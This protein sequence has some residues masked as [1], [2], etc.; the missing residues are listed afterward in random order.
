EVDSTVVSTGKTA[1]LVVEGTPGKLSPEA[2]DAARKANARLKVHPRDL[3]PNTAALAR[4]EALY[5]ELVGA[6]RA[7]LGGMIAAFRAPIESQDE[8]EIRP[9]REH[10]LA[11]T[12][13]RRER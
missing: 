11:I 5:L 8:A 9:L 4:A 3:L 10:L 13:G 7:A 1:S 12:S 2:I 6:P